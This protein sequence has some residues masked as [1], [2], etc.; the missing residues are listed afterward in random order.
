MEY[1]DARLWRVI[2]VANGLAR[3]RDL[4][5]G[6]ELLLPRLPFRDPQTGKVYA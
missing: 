3:A 5:P 1:G 6:L 4:A 2:A